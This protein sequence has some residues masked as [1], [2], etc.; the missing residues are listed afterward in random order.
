MT[1]PDIKAKVVAMGSDTL[2]DSPEAFAGR[3]AAL[4]VPLLDRCDY[5]FVGSVEAQFDGGDHV[6]FLLAPLEPGG[7][8]RA[9]YRLP[10]DRCRRC[11]GSPSRW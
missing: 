10:T 6:G 7:T 8:A 11:A 5:R 4:G 9:A 3:L 2:V 1:L